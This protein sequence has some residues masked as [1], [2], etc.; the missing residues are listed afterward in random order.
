M[1]GEIVVKVKSGSLKGSI[2]N[3]GANRYLIKTD[4]INHNEIN[5][6]RTFMLS[7]TLGIPKHRLALKSG[8]ER[9]DK[10][11]QILM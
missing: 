7:K 3:F 8:L 10:V 6:D 4:S 9:E 11:F 1:V 2:E 5:K